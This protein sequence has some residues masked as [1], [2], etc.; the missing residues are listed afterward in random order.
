MDIETFRKIG[1]IAYRKI[2]SIDE[3]ADKVGLYICPVNDWDIDLIWLRRKGIS[4]E[5]VMT[6]TL[7]QI[8]EYIDR[9]WRMKAF[10]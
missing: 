2:Q 9:L 5:T 6:G 7:D 3:A 8:K 1:V 4:P 10:L